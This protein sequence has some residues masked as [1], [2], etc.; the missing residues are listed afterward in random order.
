MYNISLFVEDR[1]QERFIVT[2][3]QRFAETYQVKISITPHS[4][5]GGSGTVITQLR[6]YQRDLQ[7]NQEEFPDLIIAGTDSNCKGF[8]EREREIS[9]A[10]SDFIRLVIIAIPEPHIERWL[11]LD[12][13]AFKAVFG[14]GCPAPD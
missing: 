14:K 13:A 10:I 6:Q 1:I 5:R 4:V 8:L 2:L 7:R 11:L 3:V 9:Q 12:S